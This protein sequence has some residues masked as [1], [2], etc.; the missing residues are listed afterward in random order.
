MRLC[1]WRIPILITP[2]LLLVLSLNT[3][4][5][6]LPLVGVNTS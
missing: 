4:I 5:D 6:T 1:A 3:W 2:T